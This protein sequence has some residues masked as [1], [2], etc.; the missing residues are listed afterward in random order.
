MVPI[1]EGYSRHQFILL[2]DVLSAIIV[3]SLTAIPYEFLRKVGYRLRLVLLCAWLSVTKVWKILPINIV[4]V[5]RGV[6]P[7]DDVTTCKKSY[8]YLFSAAQK[9]ARGHLRSTQSCSRIGVRSFR[10]VPSYRSVPSLAFLRI[11]GI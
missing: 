6:T 7:D 11:R 9:V 4:G 10:W 5:K 3:F 8:M 2:N 1:R